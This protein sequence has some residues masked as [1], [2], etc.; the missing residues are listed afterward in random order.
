MRSSTE[1][2]MGMDLAAEPT[3]RELLLGMLQK[4]YPSYHPLVSIARIAHDSTADLKLQFEC[5]KTIAKYVEPELKSIEVKGEIQGRHRVTVSLFDPVE[6]E[7][8]EVLA[9]ETGSGVRGLPPP[10]AGQYVEFTELNK[11]G[12]SED[13]LSEV[14]RKVVNW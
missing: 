14:N 9:P 5:H 1:V 6:G 4:E 8:A 3:R 11:A 2:E 10:G 7:Y 12:L 13:R